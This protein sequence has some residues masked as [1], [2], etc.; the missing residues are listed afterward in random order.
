MVFIVWV[1]PILVSLPKS[2]EGDVTF[3][4]AKEAALGRNCHAI[5]NGE[6]VVFTKVERIL[7]FTTDFAV[8]LIVVVSYAITW[9]TLNKTFKHLKATMAET[10]MHIDTKEI[11]RR[12]KSL[13]RAIILISVS[14]FA[15][16]LPFA[17]FA[18]QIP[19]DVD[20][21]K[22]IS[23]KLGVG[24][25]LYQMQFCVNFVIYAVYLGDYWEAFLDVFYLVCPCCFKWPRN[26]DSQ[27]NEI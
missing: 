16:R 7:N 13:E 27:Y 22:F 19:N 5:E 18:Q 15:L 9:W 24:I 1:F 8:L 2:F 20:G 23:I 17:F 14:Y 12:K 26:L 11:E 21:N 6:A 3:E 10:G 25:L 4:P